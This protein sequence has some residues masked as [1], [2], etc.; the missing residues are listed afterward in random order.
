MSDRY[1]VFGNPV[2]HSKSPRLHGEFARRCR[3]ELRYEAIEAPLD[4]FLD[5]VRAFVAAG[6][7]GANVTVPFKEQAHA[8]CRELSERA[9]EAEAVNTLVFRA[10]GSWYGDNTDGLGLVADLRAKG[11][12]LAGRQILVV[13]AGGAVRGILGPLLDEAPAR[14][15]LANRS[16]H[17]AQLLVQRFS[18]RGP[19]EAWTFEQLAGETFDLVV[20][21]TSAG[22]SGTLPPLPAG[23]FRP[24]ACAY[25]LVYGPASAAFLRWAKSSGAEAVY[26]GLGMLVEQAAEAFRIWRGV[27]PD[28]QGLAA[29]L[30]NETKPAI[31]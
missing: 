16:H 29:W 17:K 3:Q 22:L 9:R 7:R 4:G 13:G 2:H 24:G 19:V 14:L 5:S 28:T 11:I 23:L 1:A 6:G 15:V 10:D 12:A 25:D 20:N 31:L 27:R 18:R 26:D 21:G 30:G 8:A